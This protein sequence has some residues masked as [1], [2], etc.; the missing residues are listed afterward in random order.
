VGGL[1]RGLPHFAVL[2]D[3]DSDHR[4]AAVGGLSLSGFGS[5]GTCLLRVSRSLSSGR[6][7]SW[8]PPLPW[9]PRLSVSPWNT[10][11]S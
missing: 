4:D 6:S 11:R 3:D 10:G 5:P 9:S 7:P 8:S 1:L 2:G